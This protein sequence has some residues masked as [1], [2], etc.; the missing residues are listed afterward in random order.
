MGIHIWQPDPNIEVFCQDR[1]R[2]N[3]EIIGPQSIEDNPKFVRVL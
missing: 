1:L 3:G 2:Y